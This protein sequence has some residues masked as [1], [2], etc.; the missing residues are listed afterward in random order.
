MKTGFTIIEMMLVVIIVGIMASIGL[1]RFVRGGQTPGQQ[2]IARLNDLTQLGAQAALTT[3]TVQKINFNLQANK[4]E[5]SSID[6]KNNKTNK[7]EKSIEI[8]DD[9]EI[10]DFI[11]NGKNQFTAGGGERRS[12]YFLI[13]PD[14]ITQETQIGVLD[15]TGTITRNYQI[16]LNPFTGQFN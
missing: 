8:P 12:A 1:P 5:L 15:K 3:G 14:G 4:V 13:N 11:I 7:T 16:D 6:N 10:I 9:F 2:F